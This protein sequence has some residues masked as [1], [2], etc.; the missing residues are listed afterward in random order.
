MEIVHLRRHPVFADLP[1]LQV[2][3]PQIQPDIMANKRPELNDITKTGPVRASTLTTTPIRISSRGTGK[4]RMVTPNTNPT[5]TIKA[6]PHTSNLPKV[7]D[8]PGIR[9][10]AAET[11]TADTVIEVVT[12]E[13]ATGEVMIGE[14]LTAEGGI[15]TPVEM[16]TIVDHTIPALHAVI[17]A[18]VEVGIKVVEEGQEE[19][20]LTTEGEVILGWDRRVYIYAKY[21]N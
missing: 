18:T 21:E 5:E 10:T 4:T 14:N 13:E 1:C 19:D 17:V 12:I 20:L 11:T 7:M 2:M 6:I 9:A 8:N 15:S 3:L 16:A